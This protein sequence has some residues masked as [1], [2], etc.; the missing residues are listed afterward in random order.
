MRRIADAYRRL[1][2]DNHTAVSLLNVK[3]DQIDRV[4]DMATCSE[5]A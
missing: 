5:S 1:V 2:I 3:I 4:A